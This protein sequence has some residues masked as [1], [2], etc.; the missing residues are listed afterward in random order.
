MND[1]LEWSVPCSVVIALFLMI[2]GFAVVM[3]IIHYKEK[4]VLD[5]YYRQSK[6]QTFATVWE[7]RPEATLNQPARAQ[8]EL[9]DTAVQVQ[10]ERALSYQSQMNRLVQ[11]AAHADGQSRLQKVAQQV[12][13]WVN[14][15][16]KLA[17]QI[18][19]FQHDSLI[20]QDREAVPKIRQ[21]LE[22]RLAAETDEA[23]RAELE[24]T[25][26]NLQK[27]QASLEQ[28]GSLANRAEIQIESTLSALGT[29]YSQLLTG[30]SVSHIAD[31]GQLSAKIDEEVQ[32]LQDHLES[33]Q[34]VKLGIYK[35]S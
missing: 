18:D 33:L 16:E 2:F 27:Q 4:A 13:A 1:F 35:F 19:L 6:R 26:H 32:R 25:L 7:P 9:A 15:I 3:R 28:L 8:A 12:E 31:Y 5:E 23:N 11:Q 24:R 20:R 17:R 21:D 30:Q 34:E 10:I 29:I 14:S 22:T